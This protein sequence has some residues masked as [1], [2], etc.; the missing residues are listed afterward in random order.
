M[1][2]RQALQ[3]E[4]DISAGLILAAEPWGARYRQSPD[5]FIALTTTEARLERKL[6][7]YFRTFSERAPHLINWAQWY[8]KRIQ[9]Y[10]VEVLV[11]NDEVNTQSGLVTQVI[12]EDIAAATAIGANAGETMYRTPLGIASTDAEIQRL[13][14][15]QIGRLIGKRLNK[16]GTLVDNPKS[17]YVITDSIRRDIAAAIK[18]SITLRENEYETTERVRRTIAAMADAGKRATIIAQTES[19][20]AYNNGLLH[21]ADR[22][23]AVGKEWESYNKL[24]ICGQYAKL[25]IVKID[26]SYNDYGK[27]GPT[28]HP[29]CRCSLRLVYPSELE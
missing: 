19:V 24:D 28:A 11:T 17:E 26:Y 21:F 3:T 5:T 16:D 25:G 1:N 22:S 7:R 12:F 29:R 13:T 23:G 27:Q 8:N 4:I 6:R 9:A 10:E 15:E 14:T 20:N 2:V 18:T